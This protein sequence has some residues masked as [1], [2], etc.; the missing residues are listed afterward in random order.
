LSDLNVPTPFKELDGK[1]V[2]EEAWQAE[3]LAIAQS[4]IDDGSITGMDWA[5]A[6]GCALRVVQNEKGRDNVAGYYDAALIALEN[7]AQTDCNV[8]DAS[9]NDARKAWVNAYE[10]TPHG[11]PV[12]LNQHPNR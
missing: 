10:A 12:V 8:S 3:V 2:F 11:E 9:L 4:L 1:P 7:V 6:L 5:N